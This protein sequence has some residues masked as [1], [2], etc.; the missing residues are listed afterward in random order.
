MIDLIGHGSAGFATSWKHRLEGRLFLKQH[1]ELS[2]GGWRA[3]GGSSGCYSLIS[4]TVELTVAARGPL[5]SRSRWGLPPTPTLPEVWHSPASST[6]L[7]MPHPALGSSPWAR[8]QRLAWK[9]WNG[10]LS[11]KPRHCYWWPI[12]WF[13]FLSFVSYF[14]RVVFFSLEGPKD[15]YLWR[16]VFERIANSNWFKIKKK[17]R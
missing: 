10:W 8:L 7:L 4:S 3:V 14:W 16:F 2:G 11:P 12:C 15:W 13:L 17:G 9:S 6:R 5:K 1:Q